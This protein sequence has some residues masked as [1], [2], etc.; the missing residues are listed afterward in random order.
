MGKFVSRR[1]PHRAAWA[2]IACVTSAS[3]ASLLAAGAALAQD[4]VKIGF[5]TEL[6]GPWSFTGASCVAGLKLAEAQLNP[7]GKRRIEFVL[8]DNQ[9]QPAQAVAAA[10]NLDIQS[11]G[12][13]LSGANSSDTA[14]A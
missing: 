7:P 9:T 13:A 2:A 5:I 1:G 3:A 10:R 6:T 11:K 8:M 12:L 4:P 14:L